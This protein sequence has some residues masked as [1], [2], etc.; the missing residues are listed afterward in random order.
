MAAAVL[1]L[2]AC[3][4]DVRR[5][6]VEEPMWDDAEDRRP[7]SPAPE[8][9][10]SP[11][12]WDGA[13]Q[14]LF[15]PLTR[16]LAADPQDEATNV[17][18]FD[19]VPNSSW[20]VNR[21]GLNEMSTERVVRAACGEVTID[22]AGP[23]TVVAAKPNGANPGFI[24]EDALEQRYLLKFDSPRQPERPT[25]A[26]VMG[27]IFYWAAGF[28]SPCN[29]IVYFD[30][31]AIVIP[32]GITVTMGK[33]E[34][35]LTWDLSAT[36][37]KEAT[38]G[39]DGRIR[40]TASAF[41]PG[42]PTG[43]W[44]YEGVVD[45]DPNDVVP[46]EDRRELRGGYVL[47]SWVNHFDS[48][49][50]NTLAMFIES[51]PPNGFVRHY[52]IDFGES[53]GS[54]WGIEGISRRLGHSAYLDVGHVVQDF[55]TFGLISRPWNNARLGPTGETL[56]YYDVVRFKPDAW[57]PGYPNPAFSRATERDNAWMARIIARITPAVVNGAIDQARIVDPVVDREMRRIVLGRRQRLL[58]RW[59]ERISPLTQP[60]LTPQDDGTARLCATDLVIESEMFSPTRR[61][62][63]GRAWNIGRRSVSALALSPIER[64]VGAEVCVTLPKGAGEYVVVDLTGLSGVNDTS[65]APLRVHLARRQGQLRVVG[66][67][68]PY[69]RE[70]S[71]L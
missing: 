44:K 67:A 6:P 54:M 43:P 63:V 20:F 71:W 62:Y 56:G 30:H 18:A 11:F 36:A 61:K 47:A 7:F 39:P 51:E 10:Y 32:E 46:H 14:M 57:R 38:R 1:G 5:F 48:R 52:Y 26:D 55:L 49:E 27:S 2:G 23:W 25:A 33:E 17:N 29:R 58:T 13:D 21:V 37:L 3:G 66:V 45:D 12:A 9:Y 28:H 40:G 34:I 41:L 70:P 24:V 8:E 4:S 19:E 42:K 59:F 65:A 31:D 68:R 35:P 53:F 69:D 15:R 16:M 22:P 64:K 50:Q 60:V